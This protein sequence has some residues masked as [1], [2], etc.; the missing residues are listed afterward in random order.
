MFKKADAIS[1]T[2]EV[3]TK[4][5][6]PSLT[7]II[8]NPDPI[9]IGPSVHI[10]GEIRGNE[11]LVV[12]GHVEGTV[13]LGEGLLTITRQG[14]IDAEVHARIINIEGRAEGELHA[15]EQLMV[16]KT[17]QV[18]GKLTAP[19]VGLDFGCKF[20]G[21]IDSDVKEKAEKE[22]TDKEC[23]S[24]VTKHNVAD[25]EAAKS[26]KSDAASR[27]TTGKGSRR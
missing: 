4:S 14:R 23:A 22:K 9:P 3:R 20:S 24:E 25:F 15:R 26:G 27:S 2:G 19:R 8:R 13:D 18:R 10:K 11:D 6:V 5:S 21:S 16:R 17:A 1:G 7:S 12:H